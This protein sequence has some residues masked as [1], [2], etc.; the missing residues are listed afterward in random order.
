MNLNEKALI[1]IDGLLNLDYKHKR[2]IINLYN[3]IGEVLD[4]P[5]EAVFYLN[6]AVSNSAGNTFRLAVE[7]NLYENLLNKY[8]ERNIKVITE[9]SKNYPSNL[10]ALD[11]R[12]ICLYVTGNESLLNN[13]RTFS[14]VGSRKT[15]IDITKITEDFS[16]EL[17]NNGVTIITGVASGGDKS[18]IKGALSSGNLILVLASGHDYIKSEQNRDLI[19]KVIENG[20]VITEYPP[21]VPPRNYQYP[22]RNRI[23]AGLS[24]GTLIVSGS[25]VSGTRYTA[26][27]ALD[28][29]KEVFAFPYAIRDKSG[30]LC[31]FLIKNGA[32]LV[33]EVNDI[34]EIL[35]YDK[36]TAKKVELNGEELEIYNYIVEG[37]NTPDLI[38]LKLSKKVYEIMPI[39]SILELKK[40]IVKNSQNVYQII[41]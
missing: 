6:Q 14:I 27:Y 25:T 1:L 23:I 12:P 37:A 2:A 16:R 31:N 19:E 38:A 15:P 36:I 10:Y 35:G 41:K 5:D 34:C 28:Y 4:D 21:E 26:E 13:K 33:T 39:L 9:E 24:N 8:R 7:S 3:D 29:G 30:E 17:S 22:V 18:A 20:L 11:F 32:H 40:V